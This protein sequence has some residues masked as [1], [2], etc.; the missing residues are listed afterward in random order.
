MNKNEIR[1]AGFTEGYARGIDGKPRAMRTPMEL[2]LLA[3]KLVPTFYDAYEQGYAKGK[4]D[5][6]TLMEWRANAETMQA[7]REEQE[8]SH[9]R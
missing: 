3:P 1:D 4:D 5:F 9:E 6:R 8:K 7:A 2:I